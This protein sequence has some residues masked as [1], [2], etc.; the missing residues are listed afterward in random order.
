MTATYVSPGPLLS[1]DALY[2]AYENCLSPLLRQTARSLK[3]LPVSQS[4]RP[5]LSAPHLPCERASQFEHSTRE[6]CG[7][8]PLKVTAL[9]PVAAETLTCSSEKCVRS[10]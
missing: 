4:L 5:P 3:G 7:T 6:Q 1:Q 9:S 10:E 8:A 2:L